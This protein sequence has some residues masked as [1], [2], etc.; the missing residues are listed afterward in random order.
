MTR[1][2]LDVRGEIWV[3]I[4]HLHD[5]GGAFMI[6]AWRRLPTFWLARPS[7]TPLRLEGAC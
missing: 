5:R 7:L 3:I 2:M 6:R 1:K 4:Y